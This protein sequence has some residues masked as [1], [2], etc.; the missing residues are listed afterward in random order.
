MGSRPE[1]VSNFREQ[2]GISLSI[3]FNLFE[4]IPKCFFARCQ[5]ENKDPKTHNRRQWTEDP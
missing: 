1:R 3:P 4:S 2:G 5:F